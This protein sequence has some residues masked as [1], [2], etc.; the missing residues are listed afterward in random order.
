MRYG[1]LA[2]AVLGWAS[3]ARAGFND[4]IPPEAYINPID[5]QIART[6]K[7]MPGRP[8]PCSYEEVV[9]GTKV[10]ASSPIDRCVKMSPEQHWRGVWRNDFEGSRFCPEPATTCD[11]KT[12]GERIWL[13]GTPGQPQGG[14]YQMDFM[15]RRT[16]YKGPYGHMGGSDQELVVD[17]VI[18]MKEVEAPP[19]PPTKAEMIKYFKECEAAKTCIPNWDEI[20]K[21]E[22]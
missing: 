3:V 9:D 17:R 7:G 19:P 11:H 15:G 5:Q 22:K 13:S 6:G 16:M 14:L 8:Y 20:N 2:I 10:I 4:T 1:S 18:S 12:P 21:D